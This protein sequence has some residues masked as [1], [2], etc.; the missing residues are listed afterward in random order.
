MENLK[1]SI[2]LSSKDI[3]LIEG[4]CLKVARKELISLRDVLE[5]EKVTVKDYCN[6]WKLDM[7]DVTNCLNKYR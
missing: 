4:I 7:T 1:G 3:Q 5:K 2:L 6:Y